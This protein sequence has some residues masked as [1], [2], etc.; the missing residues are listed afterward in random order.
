[1]LI[2]I[3][4]EAWFWTSVRYLKHLGCYQ[5][6]FF[7]SST[8]WKFAGKELLVGKLEPCSTCFNSGSSACIRG[9]KPHQKD[10]L[11]SRP[12]NTQREIPNI[13]KH[14]AFSQTS[15]SVCFCLS[16]LS[17]WHCKPLIKEMQTYSF[18]RCSQRDESAFAYSLWVLSLSCGPSQNW[19]ARQAAFN[20]KECSSDVTVLWEFYG[21]KKILISYSCFHFQILRVLK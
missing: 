20:V 17:L 15:H 9:A 18:S 13:Y 16:A 1:M 5:V 12:L 7:P 6:F 8:I 14:W 11:F 10:K 19:S 4:K 2:F 3:K 21:N